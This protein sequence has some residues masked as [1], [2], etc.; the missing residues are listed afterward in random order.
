MLK[1]KTFLDL[2]DLLDETFQ[3]CGSYFYTLNLRNEFIINLKLG[4]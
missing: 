2:S 4:K 3:I 1:N